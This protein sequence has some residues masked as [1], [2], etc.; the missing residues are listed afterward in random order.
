M[1][2]DPKDTPLRRKKTTLNVPYTTFCSSSNIKPY[3]SE[4]ANN[5]L[6]S[7]INVLYTVQYIQLST[8][9]F[10]VSIVVVKPLFPFFRSHCYRYDENQLYTALLLVSYYYYCTTAMTNQ[11][12]S[13]QFL[14]THNK[15]ERENEIS[16]IGFTF[17]FLK[18]WRRGKIIYSA[19]NTLVFI[20]GCP[21]NI[22]HTR[23]E[24]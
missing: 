3:I 23:K 8:V 11:Q 14:R 2:G 4:F 1:R 24:E 7:P 10:S 22:L 19:I 15:E 9:L 12:R 13:F 20:I 21:R 17:I 18:V 6:I 5:T 16:N